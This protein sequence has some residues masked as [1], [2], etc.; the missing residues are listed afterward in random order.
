MIKLWP[1]ATQQTDLS[2]LNT[3]DLGIK[4]VYLPTSITLLLKPMDRGTISTFKAY[5][6]RT[7]LNGS[8]EA[9]QGPD[10]SC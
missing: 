6:L 7:T 2:D 4:M 9:V 3:H 8:S 5:C 10:M 1:V